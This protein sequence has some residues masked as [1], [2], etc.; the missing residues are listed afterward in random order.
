MIP[1]PNTPKVLLV[2]LDGTLVNTLPDRISAINYML[3]TLDFPKINE[4][5]VQSY[6]G[7]GVYILAQKTLKESLQATPEQITDALIQQAADL[8][9]AY[10]LEHICIKSALYPNVL[11]TLQKVS[12]QDIKI[13][14]I[15]NKRSCHSKE[16]I[17]ALNLEQYFTVIM[18]GE[19][20]AH[21]P[22]PDLL[23]HALKRMNVSPNEA[24]MVGDSLDDYNAATSA[25]ISMIG[26]SYGYRPLVYN[27][28]P[29]LINNFAELIPYFIKS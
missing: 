9:E 27:Q 5:N 3:T 6:I 26:V 8:Y 16:L 29:I 23:L 28:V 11:E 15:T 22:A 2:D 19:D 13:A 12:A 14:L 20:G 7:D 18:G 17:Y 24:I 4:T 25:H 21:K 10:Y 1:L